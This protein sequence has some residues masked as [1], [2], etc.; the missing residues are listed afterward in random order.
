MPAEQLLVRPDALEKNKV[1]LDVLM[2][3][4]KA[5]TR[6]EVAVFLASY[7]RAYECD[8]AASDVLSEFLIRYT[9][10]FPVQ[11]KAVF[12]SEYTTAWMEGKSFELPPPPSSMS[13]TGASVLPTAGFF[14]STTIAGVTANTGT[15][16]QN[17]SQATSTVRTYAPTLGCP[18]C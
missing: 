18:G 13:T 8:P 7:S 1:R 4:T 11:E 5:L 16:K 9:K 3:Y 17:Q 2:N 10:S 12:V 15:P 6:D 14:S